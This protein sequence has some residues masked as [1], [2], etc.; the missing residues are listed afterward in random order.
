MSEKVFVRLKP[1][2]KRRGYLCRRFVYRGA[3]FRAGEW[4]KVSKMVADELAKLIQP[5]S[6]DK[7]LPLFDI[8]KDEKAAEEIRK[9]DDPEPSTK[10]EAA[11]VLEDS[12]FRGLEGG[13]K[14]PV[15][16]GATLLEPEDADDDGGEDGGDGETKAEESAEGKPKRRR[17]RTRST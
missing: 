13:R 6:E 15:K 7:P 10:P 9:A 2:N 11:I 14:E 3:L 8:G 17:A 12:S 5:R 1:T 16:Q 4:R